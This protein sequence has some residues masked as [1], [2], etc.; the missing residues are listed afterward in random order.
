MRW[1]DSSDYLYGIDLFNNGFYWEAHEAW[2]SLWLAAGKA[3]VTA[4]FLKGLI[5]LAAAALKIREGRW[6]GA[7]HLAEGAIEHLSG[8]VASTGSPTYA[9]LDIA[10]VLRMAEGL[11]ISIREGTTLSSPLF[12]DPL[13]LGNELGRCTRRSISPSSAPGPPDSWPASRRVGPT[14]ARGIVVLDGARSIG[15][16]IR[17]SGGGRCNVTHERVDETAFAGSSRH[18]IRKVLLRFDVPRTIAFF[19]EIGVPLKREETGKLFPVTDDARTVARRPAARG[20]RRQGA[21]HRFPWR[22]E[23][24]ER[25]TATSSS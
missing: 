7:D 1:R 6:A 10:S 5:K 14:P 17:I 18:A 23:T 11:R 4:E 3:G 25:P 15:A 9:G 2:E 22:V 16:K 24:I 21:E 19:E 8:V 13:I 20:A 12:P